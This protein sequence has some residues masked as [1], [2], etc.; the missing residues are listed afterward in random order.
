[1]QNDIGCMWVFAQDCV[2]CMT[3][4][5]DHLP[6]WVDS[7]Q[8]MLVMT[9]D[10]FAPLFHFK[11]LRLFVF[12]L[13]ASQKY[14]QMCIVIVFVISFVIRVALSVCFPSFS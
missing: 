4:E 7:N 13:L 6:V 2:Y 1:M 14:I 8:C 9:V 10:L 11:Y 5:C 3:D 12:L